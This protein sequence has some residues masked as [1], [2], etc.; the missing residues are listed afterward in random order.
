[1]VN[2]ESNG[3][4][5]VKH[6][7]RHEGPEKHIIAFIFSIVL[8]LIAFAAVA[9]GGVNTAFT[10]ILL[11]VMA[12]LQVLIQLGYWMHMKDKGHLIPIIFMAGGFFVAFT[13]IIAALYWMW[14]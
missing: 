5:A 2:Q 11:L 12:V 10:V 4:P 7:Q 13:A 1:M 14:W 3:S 6:R 8:T 9:A